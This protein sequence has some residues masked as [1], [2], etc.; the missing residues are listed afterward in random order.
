[1][2]LDHRLMLG[3]FDGYHTVC[4]VE[5]ILGYQKRQTQ[6]IVEGDVQIAQRRHR[7]A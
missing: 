2:P 5:V 7:V 1:M 3:L 6:V 4:R